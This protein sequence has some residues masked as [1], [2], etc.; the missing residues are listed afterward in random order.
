VPGPGGLYAQL[1]VVNP[2]VHYAFWYTLEAEADRVIAD[3]DDVPAI[4]QVGGWPR[5][6]LPVVPAIEAA[7]DRCAD[8][9]ADGRRV[10]V[11][12]RR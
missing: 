5:A 6:M 8:V 9:Q 2:T 7:Y 3:L 10:V 4:L 12:T 11:W 1:D